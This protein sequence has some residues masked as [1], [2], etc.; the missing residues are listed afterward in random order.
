MIYFRLNE[1][2]RKKKV[3]RSRQNGLTIRFLLSDTRRPN[4][5]CKMLEA[6]KKVMSIKLNKKIVRKNA[7]KIR[8]ILFHGLGV[9]CC[10]NVEEIY[11]RFAPSC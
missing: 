7:R 10:H 4:S 11:F 1:K 6:V 8:K 5:F 3:L 2:E 9:N